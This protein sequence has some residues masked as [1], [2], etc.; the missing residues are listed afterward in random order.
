MGGTGILN[1]EAEAVGTMLVDSCNGFNELIR[2]VMLWTVRHR[3]NTGDIFSFNC[4][5]YWAQII[6]HRPGHLPVTLM[7]WEGVTQGYPL[8]MALYGS[9]LVTL[10]EELWDVDPGLLSSFYADNTAFFRL[11]SISM[12]LMNLIQEW[13]SY[14]GVI[15]CS[16]QVP[17]HS[18]L[19]L[20]GG[21]GAVNFLG[22]GTCAEVYGGN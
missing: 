6:L 3:W 11:D 12:Q 2:L 5:K 13:G 20:P 18:G 9:T 16:V 22:G 21:G 7:S 15:F 19:A 8:S 10:E 1:Q 17:I 4:Y 14:H